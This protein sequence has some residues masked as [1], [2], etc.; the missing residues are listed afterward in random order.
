MLK[1]ILKKQTLP[2]AIAFLCL[3]N[4]FPITFAAAPATL[5][6]SQTPLFLGGADPNITFILDASGSMSW[7]YMPDNIGRR[8]LNASDAT[9]NTITSDSAYSCLTSGWKKGLTSSA[10]NKLYYDPATTYSPPLK[11]DGTSMPNASYTGAWLDG[12][13]TSSGTLDLSKQYQATWGHP[14]NKSASDEGSKCVY[15]D[16]AVTGSGASVRAAYY[17]SLTGTAG[18]TTASINTNLAPPADSCFTTNTISSSSGPS[19]SRPELSGAVSTDERTNFANWFSYYRNRLNTAKTGTSRAFAQTGSNINLGYGKLNN[20]T[21]T[22]DGVS[23]N[24]IA[25]G[26]RPFKDDPGQSVA[27]NQKWRSDFFSWLFNVA[28]TGGTPL[29]DALN[30]AGKYYE[31]S[32]AAYNSKPWDPSNGNAVSCRQSYTIMTTDGYWRNNSVS[33]GNAD[34]TAGTNIS[35]VDASGNTLTYQYLQKDPFKDGN[36]NTLADVAMYYWKRDLKG[37]LTNNVP[38]STSDPA[39]W[40][41]MVTFPIGLGVSG[42]VSQLTAESAVATETSINWGSPSTSGTADNIDDLLHASINSRGKYFSAQNPT[43]FAE[44]LSAA[45]SDIGNRPSASLT[46]SSTSGSA[47]SDTIIY[48]AS[49]NSGIWIGDVIGYKFNVTTGALTQVASAATKIPV[50]SG[51]TIY[52]WKPAVGVVPGTGIQFQNGQ[53]TTTQTAAL[54]T[55]IASA[56]LGALTP[57]ITPADIVSYVRGNQTK[58]LSN[59]GNL[60]NRSSLFGDVINSGPVFSGRDNYGYR[61]ATSLPQNV[62]DAY[63]AFVSS[64]APAVFVGANDGM[65]HALNGSSGTNAL[66]ELFTYVPNEVI[67]NLPYLAKP[68]NFT[69]RP[70]VD[71]PVTVEHAYF[72]GGWKRILIGSTGAGGKAYFALNVT[73]PSTPSVLWEYTDT[74]LGN[75]LGAAK[76]ARLPNGKWA[77]IFGNGYNS[78]NQTASLFILDLETGTLIKKLALASWNTSLANGLATPFV[79]DLDKDGTIDTAYAGDLQGGLWKFDLSDTSSSNWKVAFGGTPLFRTQNLGTI[80]SPRGQP[81]TTEPQVAFHKLGGTIVTFG[82]GKFFEVG[83]QSNTEKQS[84]YGIRDV[85]GLSSTNTGCGTI[86]GASK[87]SLTDLV[88]QTFTETTKTVTNSTTGKSYTETLRY[89]SKNV[90]TTKMGYYLDLLVGSTETGERV[91]VAPLLFPKRVFFVSTTPNTDVCGT[92]GTSWL[93]QLNLLTG[94]ET[95]DSVFD[96]N[97]DGLFDT[98]DRGN[99]VKI[100]SIIGAP[101]ILKGNKGGAAFVSGSSGAPPKDVPPPNQKGLFGRQSW[102][103][104][105]NY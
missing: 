83:D 88:K 56:G 26:V 79:S 54:T 58:E 35:G 93:W 45:L 63:P 78:T 9:L 82:T 47:S 42:N 11:A 14:T 21:S 91:T 50:E 20:G 105:S 76:I 38:A 100:N 68:T 51:R 31:N 60:R 55:G 81:I 15:V 89:V 94:G 44:G 30:D 72:N 24:T 84:F 27:A 77:A 18:C 75:T 5:N 73:D 90:D 74:D 95:D 25:R 23:T 80:S 43:E 87:V 49:F 3:A 46:L 70:Y 34:G 16:S 41:H 19:R 13:T 39:F 17:N 101:L 98:N 59:G 103:Q 96:L 69:H 86:S 6:L 22:V 71:G 29:P 7:S 67:G 57:T 12:F 40:Q 104:L 66:S 4:P 61:T 10:Y 85:C 65:L 48:L 37:S 52:T 102:R 53:L 36:S 99:A 33:V 32:A 64:L 8:A 2:A 1:N 28:S 92:G 62:R 97:R